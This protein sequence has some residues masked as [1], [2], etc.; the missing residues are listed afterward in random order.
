MTV[1]LLILLLPI[2]FG[3]ALWWRRKIDRTHNAFQ[4]K[5]DLA[6]DED[7]VRQQLQRYYDKQSEADTQ[8]N[9]KPQS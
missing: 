8:P 5:M 3:G 7:H 9:E 1:W 2:A 6:G 4:T